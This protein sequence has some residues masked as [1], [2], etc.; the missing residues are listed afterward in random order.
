MGATIYFLRHGQT[1]NNKA[2]VFYGHTDVPLNEEG[3][4][5]AVKAGKSLKKVRF[6]AVYAS[7]LLRAKNTAK[8]A[9]E[10][11][12][13]PLDISYIDSLKEIHFGDWEGMK[14]GDIEMAYKQNW[15][16]YIKYFQKFTFPNGENVADYNQRAKN[17]MQELKTKHLNGNILVVSH[18]G[19][20]LSAISSLLHGDS[21][22][23]FKYDIGTGKT[24][25]VECFGDFCV[26]RSLN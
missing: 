17:Y 11:N 8:I 6:E 13:Y 3:Y 18:K 26:L 14:A 12:N 1:D 15:S 9:M 10:Q 20:I 2:N 23:M 4:I 16:E 21:T 7:P 24:A 22:S 25:V 19:F 5:E